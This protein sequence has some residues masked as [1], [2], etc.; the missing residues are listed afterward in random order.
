MLR[1]RSFLV[2]ITVLLILVVW[3]VVRIVTLAVGVIS[4]WH[5]LGVGRILTVWVLVILHVIWIVLPAIL[6][7][8]LHGCFFI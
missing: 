4:I 6:S 2:V 7:T 1:N 5:V 8:I 3:H